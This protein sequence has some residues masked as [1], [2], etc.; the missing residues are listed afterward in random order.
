MGLV[1]VWFLLTSGN[2]YTGILMAWIPSVVG[3]SFTLKDVDVQGIKVCSTVVCVGSVM[4]SLGGRMNFL[5]TP[6]R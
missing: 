6:R 1:L 3:A 4:V 2:W 5:F